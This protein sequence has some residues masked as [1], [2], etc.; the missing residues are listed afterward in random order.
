MVVRRFGGAG[1]FVL[2]LVLAQWV[3]AQ[4]TPYWITD[5][6]YGKIFKVQNGAV[7]QV[8]TEPVTDS[9][10]P[11]AFADT[12]RTLNYAIGDR[13]G[14]EYLP[15][16]APTANTFALQPGGPNQLTDGTTDGVNYNYAISWSDGGVWRFNRQ[17][18]S[19]QFMFA[20]GTNFNGITYDTATGTLW[21]NSRYTT[22]EDY[23]TILK[24]YTVAGALLSSVNLNALNGP[25]LAYERATDTLW[26]LGYSVLDTSQHQLIHQYSKTGTLLTTIELPNMIGGNALG[27]EMQLPEPGALSVV[28]LGVVLMRRR[29]VRA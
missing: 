2:V 8:I 22:E 4:S 14:R 17:W 21:V 19:P 24:N 10:Y 27:G 13:Q 26:M 7:Q 16:G 25:G 1:A 29:R 18:G 6:Y 3:V 12:V 23:S 28:G 20:A 9:S 11:L 15:N 5:G